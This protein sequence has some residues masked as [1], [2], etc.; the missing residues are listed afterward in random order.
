MSHGTCHGNMS[1]GKHKDSK[2][3]GSDET[4]KINQMNVIFSK[5]IN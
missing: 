2:Q 4:E 3:H 1:T 5:I